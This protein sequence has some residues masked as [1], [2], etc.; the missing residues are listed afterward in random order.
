MA[1]KWDGESMV[2]VGR[3]AREC[4]VWTT[5]PSFPGYSVSTLGRVR[6]DAII[7]GG[8]GSTR[9]PKGALK[10]RALP[11]G[12]L[13]VTLSV[14]NK[15]TTVLVHRLV[16]EAF[17]P[18]PA[19]GQDCVCHR[20]DNPANNHPSNLFWGTRADNAADKVSKGRQGKGE[21][22]ASA[23]LTADVV[24]S[25]R[26]LA[27]AGKEQRE[28]AEMFGVSQ[29]NISCIVTRATWKHVP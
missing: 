5:I 17:L 18:P 22:I 16:A 15:P 24:R 20:D 11:L 1:F 13:Q 19:P 25:I 4:E 14:G 8:C 23:K 9:I 12:H 3:F 6:R 27:A 26:A 29:S 7:R 28:L 10:Q 21:S 2:P